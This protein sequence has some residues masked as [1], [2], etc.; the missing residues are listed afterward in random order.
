MGYLSFY[1]LD[2]SLVILKQSSAFPLPCHQHLSSQSCQMVHLI[3][4]GCSPGKTCPNAKIRNAKKTF[5]IHVSLHTTLHDKIHLREFCTPT[6]KMIWVNA[7]KKKD[8]YIT[9][10]SCYTKLFLFLI[11]DRLS[12]CRAL[13]HCSSDFI[14]QL[15][16]RR[17]FPLFRW[18]HTCYVS[19]ISNKA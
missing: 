16:M 19:V 1:P 7:L 18:V 6:R 10:I 4:W 5:S 2:V 12:F 9:K 15:Y 8:D 13:T 3:S 11:Y 17:L 14:Q